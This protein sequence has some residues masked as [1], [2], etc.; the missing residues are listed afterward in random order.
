[1]ER[2]RMIKRQVTMTRA[3]WEKLQELS[4]STRVPA[5]VFMREGIDRVLDLAEK[6]MDAIDRAKRV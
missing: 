5:A 3:Q 6:Q 2:V 4:R 1:M